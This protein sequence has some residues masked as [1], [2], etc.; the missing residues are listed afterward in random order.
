MDIK[1]HITYIAVINLN[2]SLIFR[3]PILYALYLT[4]FIKPISP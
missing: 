2:L 1:S 3:K 4:G